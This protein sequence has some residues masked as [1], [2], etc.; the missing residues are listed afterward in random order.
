MG[1]VKPFL[2]DYLFLFLKLPTISFNLMKQMLR[3]DTLYLLTR[4]NLTK[5]F[6]MT[7]FLE[8]NLF[9]Q[10]EKLTTISFTE[11]YCCYFNK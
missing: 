9:T 4:Q 6:V 5:I 7:L 3:K 8:K 2:K 10:N 1:V 11:I